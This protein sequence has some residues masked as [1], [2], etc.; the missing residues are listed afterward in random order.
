[1][2][3]W[4]NLSWWNQGWD[5]EPSYNSYHTQEDTSWDTELEE[6]L[7]DIGYDFGYEEESFDEGSYLMEDGEM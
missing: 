6:W 2:T 5:S 1:M 4:D 3:N 7:V